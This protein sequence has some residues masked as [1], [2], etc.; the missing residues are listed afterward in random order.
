MDVPAFKDMKDV[1]E[2]LFESFSS[3]AQIELCETQNQ[4]LIKCV[5]DGIKSVDVNM[6]ISSWRVILF[7][8]FGWNNNI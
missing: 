4:Q 1:I 7:F 3:F 6:A 8:I 5:F 2:I